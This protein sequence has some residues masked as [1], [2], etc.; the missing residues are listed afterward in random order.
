MTQITIKCDPVLGVT[1]AIDSR[2][3]KAASICHPDDVFDEKKGIELAIQR[4]MTPINY[5]DTVVIKPS[6]NVIEP[7]FVESRLANY[8]I[9]Y[10]VIRLGVLPGAYL[11]KIDNDPQWLNTKTGRL[12][13][14]T[15]C[16]ETGDGW[17]IVE[18]RLTGKIAVTKPDYIVKL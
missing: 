16:Y 10:C 15:L 13:Q 5:D 1:T 14:Y 18:N 17:S 7:P 12:V 8:I 9:N 3:N 2:G 4:L 11:D 6:P